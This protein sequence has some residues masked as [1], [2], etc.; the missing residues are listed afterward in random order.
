M[1]DGS[2]NRV[3]VCV[4]RVRAVPPPK[5]QKG[6]KKKKENP[7]AVQKLLIH[8]LAIAITPLPALV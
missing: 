8:N 5:F 1:A 3:L 6:K 7:D 2:K 4:C